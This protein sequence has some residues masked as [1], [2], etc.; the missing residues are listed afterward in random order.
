MKITIANIGTPGP[1]GDILG[2][3]AIPAKSVPVFVEFDYSQSIG[4][5]HVH[6]DGSADLELAAGLEIDVARLEADRTIGLGYRVLEEHRDGDIRVID[7]LELMALGVS[8]ALILR[9]PTG[10]HF[11]PCTWACSHCGEAG[12]ARPHRR[13]DETPAAAVARF[14]SDTRGRCVEGCTFTATGGNDAG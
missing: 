6:A 3:A 1:N 8:S 4:V 11:V 10:D 13:L 7:K 12:Q 9:T 2:A 5:A 14:A